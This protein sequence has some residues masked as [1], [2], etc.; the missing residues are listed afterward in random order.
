MKPVDMYSEV[1]QTVAAAHGTT[2]ASQ[3]EGTPTTWERWEAQ[4]PPF[5]EM[6]NCNCK[7]PLQNS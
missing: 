1:E 4:T 3:Q 6:K 5:D 7:T 2:N